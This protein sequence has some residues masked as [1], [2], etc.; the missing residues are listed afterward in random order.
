MVDGEEYQKKVVRE[1]HDKDGHREK[2]GTY[3]KVST[4][5][6]WPG[7]HGTV[8]KHTRECPECQ[9]YSPRREEEALHPTWTAALWERVSMD[10]V[11]MPTAKSGKQYLVVAREYLSGWSEARALTNATSEAVA[12]FLWEE[13]ICRWGVFG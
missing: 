5:Y 7:F 1:M 9:K 4:P 2:E 3:T 11:Y 8:K 6:W 13:V 10:I 12:K